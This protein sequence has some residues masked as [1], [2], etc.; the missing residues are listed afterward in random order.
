MS[1]KSYETSTIDQYLSSRRGLDA[2]LNEIEGD[3]NQS[4]NTNAPQ[5]AVVHDTADAAQAE[6]IAQASTL[7]RRNL[8]SEADRAELEDAYKPK[9][10][11]LSAEVKPGVK[12]EV[13]SVQVKATPV[14]KE[15]VKPVPIVE[16]VEQKFAP[17]PVLTP[18]TVPEVEP[19]AVPNALALALR[20]IERLKNVVAELSVVVVPAIPAGSPYVSEVNQERFGMTANPKPLPD[21]GDGVYGLDE[22]ET[23]QSIIDGVPD[24]SHPINIP[25]GA[26]LVT[27][28]I[29]QEERFSPVVPDTIKPISPPKSKR[30][31]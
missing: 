6:Q 17:V 12:P 18:E 25:A 1:T 30:R 20:E 22:L 21:L 8:F 31:K 3:K 2:L 19:N 16:A 28:E 27:L 15:F 5:M 23:H 14:V 4:Y 13:K 11:K 29:G 24:R 9:P 26:T 10:V 7:F